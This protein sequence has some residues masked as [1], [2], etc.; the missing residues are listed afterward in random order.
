MRKVQP[1]GASEVARTSSP[2]IRRHGC[3]VRASRCANIGFFHQ[4]SHR[5][6]CFLSAGVVATAAFAQPPAKPPL[7]G[8]AAWANVSALGRKAVATAPGSSSKAP[9]Q[10]A[11]DKQKRATDFRRVSQAAK[12]FYTQHPAH[13][14]AAA[15]RKLEATAAIEGISDGDKVHEQAALKTADDYRKNKAVFAGDRF[16]V[17]HAVERHHLVRKNGG[18]AWHARPSASEDMTD[19][20]RVE[21]GDIPHVHSS[22]LAVAEAADSE[23]SGDVAAKVLQMRASPAVRRQ[24]ESIYERWRL[25]GRKLDLTLATT[26]GKALRL[27][28]VTSPR[29]VIYLWEGHR[30]PKGPAGLKAAGQSAPAGTRWIY[31]SLGAFTGKPA[32]IASRGTPAGT[33]CVEPLGMRSPL[34]EQLRISTLPMVI[35]LDATGAVVSFGKPADLPSLLSRERT[36]SLLP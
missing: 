33:Y 6:R 32:D 21:F 25:L 36:V 28:Q 23:Y 35:V 8:D 11:T 30:D 24:A 19:R 18:K 34:V 7:A 5:A 9:A 15:A 29:T 4:V 3:D 1:T 14:N 26:D 17:A 20:L 22:Y 31:V 27:D 16:E 2:G 13:P 12:E 10:A